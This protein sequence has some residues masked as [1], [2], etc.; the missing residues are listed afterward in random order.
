MEEGE[1]AAIVRSRMADDR[2]LKFVNSA[3]YLEF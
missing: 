2:R 1:E 3:K